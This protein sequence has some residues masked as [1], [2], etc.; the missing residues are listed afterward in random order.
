ME[1]VKRTIIL[2]F[3]LYLIV[4]LLGKKQIKNLTLF[5]YVLSISI[6]SIT[7][8]SIISIDTPISNGVI[9]III[10]GVIGYI[11]SLVTTHSQLAEEIIDG[12]PIVL[13]ENGNFNYHNLEVAKL[14]ISK[15]LENCRIKGCFDINELGCAILEPS[16]EISILL[17]EA[18]QPITNNDVKTNIQKQTKK[19][20]INYQIIVDGELNEKELEQSEKSEQ[21]LEKYLK[22][23]KLEVNDISLLTV[24]KN[25]KVN[26]LT[27][28]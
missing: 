13:F 4:K 5:D 16:G 21:W 20:T 3:A 15:V 10:F 28:K 9:A 1:I 18:Y 26:L 11:V 23:N 7:A 12:E 24:D 25:D 27:Y 2:F 8:D 17:K 6:G 14:S 19:Q 22:K